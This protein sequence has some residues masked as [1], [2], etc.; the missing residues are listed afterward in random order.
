[1]KILVTGGMGYI[2]TNLHAAIPQM[3]MR[4]ITF[5]G[6]K[7][8]LVDYD[9][10]NGFNVLNAEQLFD[11]IREVDAVIHL[12]AVSGIVDCEKEPGHAT[13]VNVDGTCMASGFA[14]GLNKPF[15][16][17]SSFAAES[18]S[19]VYGYTKKLAEAVV[20]KNRGVVCRLSNVYGGLEYL[21]RK[22]SVVSY[23]KKCQEKEE[24]PELHDEGMHTRDF[25]H[26]VDACHG[27]VEALRMSSGIY[28]IC[29]GKLTSVADLA[30]L[31]G[32]KH[33]KSIPMP[34]DRKPLPEIVQALPGW[35]PSI[36]LKEGLKLVMD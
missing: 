4:S 12:A 21:T 25:I 19:N 6:A 36:S 20:L 13:K 2:G 14:T 5:R 17:A 30:K 3:V 23:L 10:L 11:A 34:E 32:F 31:M 27:L 9:M 16:L 24:I 22:S 1:M 33:L 18:P 7:L 28:K 35:K 29:T 26:V 15:V 8:D